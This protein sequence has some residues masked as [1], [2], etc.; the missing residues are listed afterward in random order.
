MNQVRLF[1]NMWGSYTVIVSDKHTKL[2]LT[3]KVFGT[4]NE[5]VG[6]AVDYGYNGE[7]YGA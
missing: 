2:V 4:K 3:T 6:Y 7:G 1:K 5:A